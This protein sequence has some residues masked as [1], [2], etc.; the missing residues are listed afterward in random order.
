MEKLNRQ[1]KRPGATRQLYHFYL[2]PADRE[3]IQEHLNEQSART[4]ALISFSAFVASAV[5]RAAQGSGATF[6][7]RVR[8]GSCDRAAPAQGERRCTSNLPASW[9][10]RLKQA[11][12]CEP[13]AAL[14]NS[15]EH[16]ACVLISPPPQQR[17]DPPADDGPPFPTLPIQAASTPP[18]RSYPIP[19]SLW[20]GYMP[21]PP[22]PPSTKKEKP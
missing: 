12:V 5:L 22:I 13:C 10:N 15:V 6:Y 2:D 9:W 18:A 21:P 4:G 8:D 1:S 7:G 14:I 16:R 11:W 17:D 3:V 20:N 19:G